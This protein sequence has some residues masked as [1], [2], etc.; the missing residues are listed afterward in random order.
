M[1]RWSTHKSSHFLWMKGKSKMGIR[2]IKVWQQ[3]ISSSSKEAGRS[4]LPIHHQLIWVCPDHSIAMATRPIATN[5]IPLPQVSLYPGHSLKNPILPRPL[6]TNGLA[7]YLSSNCRLPLPW[8]WQYQS[9]FR[10]FHMTVAIV[11][12]GWSSKYSLNLGK[13]PVSLTNT[14]GGTRLTPSW[15]MSSLSLSI[16]EF[17]T[18]QNVSN[19]PG[20]L[21][22]GFT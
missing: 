10:T 20:L 9:D 17:W 12:Y 19:P 16:S 3:A 1:K 18:F 15:S 8:S 21:I 7:T 2:H 4:Q 6:I 22:S 5:T 11:L 14:L 13:L